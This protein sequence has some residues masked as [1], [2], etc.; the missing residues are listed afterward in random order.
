MKDEVLNYVW[1]LA[2]GYWLHVTFAIIYYI[3]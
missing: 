2:I 1:H 3:S